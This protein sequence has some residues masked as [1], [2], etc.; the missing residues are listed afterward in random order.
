MFIIR[1]FTIIM[2]S[3][4]QNSQRPTP[5]PY[6]V[7]LPISRHVHSFTASASASEKP[8]LP[9]EPCCQD[10]EDHERRQ[11]DAIVS[12]E[13]ATKSPTRLYQHSLIPALRSDY[14]TEG[15]TPNLSSWGDALSSWSGIQEEETRE[16][17]VEFNSPARQDSL[18]LDPDFCSIPPSPLDLSALHDTWEHVRAYCNNMTTVG[19]IKSSKVAQPI[20][21]SIG[22]RFQIWDSCF[23]WKD[24]SLRGV[25]SSQH[26]NSK[27]LESSARSLHSPKGNLA[28]AAG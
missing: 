9:T 26:Q 23:D 2:F 6:S 17:N 16:A 15:V 5:S 20:L 27:R 22:C 8:T 19:I 1:Y 12:Y 28:I 13:E 24:Q 25:I 18:L 11:S 10:E 7:L 4:S 21:R 3:I 14:R